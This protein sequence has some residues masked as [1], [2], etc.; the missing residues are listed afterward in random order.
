MSLSLYLC[1]GMELPLLGPYMVVQ[2]LGG[3]IGAGLA[4]VRDNNDSD[5]REVSPG[6][7]YYLFYE[8]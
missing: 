7:L 2:M 3:M 6:L 8:H 4:K 5:L 1:G